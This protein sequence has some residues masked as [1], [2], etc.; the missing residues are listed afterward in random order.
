MLV[1]Y[2]PLQVKPFPE[3]PL[4]QAHVKFPGVFLHVALLLHGLD[5]H[6]SISGQLKLTY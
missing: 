4:L 3:K 6:S 5:R 2:L 1:S